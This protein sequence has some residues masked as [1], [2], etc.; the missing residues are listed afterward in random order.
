MRSCTGQSQH[1]TA[2]E[3]DI[4]VPQPWR[5]NFRLTSHPSLP[6]TEGF[7]GVDF[8]CQNWESPGQTRVS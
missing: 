4:Q 3:T 2:E 7:L 6:G 1:C 8:Q 5:L